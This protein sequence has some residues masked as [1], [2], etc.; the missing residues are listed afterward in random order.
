MNKPVN[1]TVKETDMVTFHCNATG[2]PLPNVTWYKDGKTVAHGETLRFESNRNNSGHYW[3][4]AENGL[5]TVMNTS[6][7]LDVLCK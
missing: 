6:A 5:K 3:C 1:Q 4:M 7:Y 2:N